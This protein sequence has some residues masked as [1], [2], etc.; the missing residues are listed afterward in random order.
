M[1]I[2]NKKAF[3][4]V[5]IMVAIVCTFIVGIGFFA[6]QRNLSK[7]DADLKVI[8]TIIEKKR[9]FDTV[10]SD[11]KAFLNTINRPEN[12][13]MACLRNGG[14]CDNRYIANT[15][16]EN[17]DRI[18]VYDQN[19]QLFYDGRATNTKGFT[20]KGTACDG[21][22]YDGEGN[23][24]CPI[25]F[26]VSWFVGNA[27]VTKANNITFVAKMVYNPSDKN[28]QKRKINSQVN[29]QMSAY[30]SAQ[31][32][33]LKDRPN[34]TV[35][36]C[37][38]GSTEIFN[39][40]VYRF[41]ETANVNIGS[42][43]ASEARV[44]TVINGAASLSG[45]YT[46]TTCTQNCYGEFSSCTAPCGGGTRTF[47]RQ[48]ERNDW[49]LD[50]AYPTGYTEACN[51]QSCAAITDCQVTWGPCSQP[52][53]GGQQNFTITTP[54]ANGGLACPTGPRACNTQSCAVPTD[55]Q[56]TWA[57]C[58]QTCGGGQQA[59][60]ISTAPTNGGAAC[61]VSP[62]T[63][64]PQACPPINPPVDCAGTWGSCS[65]TCG[66]GQQNF[67]VTTPASNGGAAC[68]TSPRDCNTQACDI[69]CAGDWGSCSRNCGGGT[70][71]F[72]ATATQSGNG[73]ACPISPRSCNEQ[74]CPTTEPPLVVV[75]CAGTW[76]SCSKTC[77]G[78]SQTFAVTTQPAN[79]GLA[80]P[81]SRACNE[82]ACPVDCAGSWGS[83]SKT[84][85]GGEEVF[86]MT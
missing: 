50:C 56:G 22:K 68:P 52:C 45:S 74:A 5:E 7:G 84:C 43:C 27:D 40:G 15:Y 51:T 62:R 33:S 4:L 67:V 80:C 64:N 32:F 1:G 73:V 77:G 20:D 59:F 12:A 82:Q 37:M 17:Q 9:V 75:D 44:C 70:Q 57:P 23:D 39:G 58:S 21:F 19:N 81:T 47:T 3:S 6:I 60:V 38:Q 54:A 36:S 53:G 35:I 79:G 61:P 14:S 76:G 26:A 49:G 10:L 31:I 71:Y 28:S 2:R 72:N 25:G 42:T 69:D 66:T 34:T 16:N 8:N 78:G 24:E 30:D 11:R 13:N 46:N 41:F 86:N 65:A 29:S 18:V 85:G 83:C 48:I 55:C 63:C